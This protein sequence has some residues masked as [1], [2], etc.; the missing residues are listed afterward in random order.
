[1]EINKQ[2]YDIASLFDLT[3]DLSI[4]AET[5][6]RCAAVELAYRN[7]PTY[8]IQ[9]VLDDI[10]N[11]SISMTIQGIGDPNEHKL[12]TEGIKRVKG[13]IHSEKY[14]LESAVVNASK[15]AYL[16]K[17]IEKGSTKVNHFVANNTTDLIDT[18][19]VAPLPTKLNKLKKTNIE[20]FYYWSEVQKLMH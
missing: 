3:K 15:A 8:D 7:L 17:I 6:R 20:A 13:F 10:F 2:L 1:M 11:T 19:I 16:S 18:E 14:G 4:T 9:Q 5:F 12:L